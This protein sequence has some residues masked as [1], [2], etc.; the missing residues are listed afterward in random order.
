MRVWAP[1]GGAQAE[2]AR[3]SAINK[4]GDAPG[5]VAGELGGSRLWP[6]RHTLRQSQC[7]E[8]ISFSSHKNGPKDDC[9]LVMLNGLR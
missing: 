1:S 2:C 4:Q 8:R 7:V 9:A 5:F 3:F 6:G